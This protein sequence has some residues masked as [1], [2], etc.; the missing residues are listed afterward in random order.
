MNVQ[1]VM[2]GVT[3]AQSILSLFST[4]KDLVS[5]AKQFVAP[6]ADSDRRVS[7]I[8]FSRFM[9][10]YLETEGSTDPLMMNDVQ[11]DDTVVRVAQTVAQMPSTPIQSYRFRQWVMTLAQDLIHSKDKNTLLSFA[12]SIHADYLIA[13]DKILEMTRHLKYDLAHLFVATAENYQLYLDGLDE[14]ERKNAL[15]FIDWTDS[16]KALVHK[17]TE[18]TSQPLLDAMRSLH[19]LG[20][21]SQG[22]I[23]DFLCEIII[24]YFESQV[25]DV[26]LT[27]SASNKMKP[28][29][30]CP[31]HSLSFDSGDYIT[32][33]INAP[34]LITAIPLTRLSR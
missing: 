18:G 3:T 21:V 32:L 8:V 33:D 23:T 28:G 7:D 29:T 11:I 15:S 31:E 10:L 30:L 17:V 22:S 2:A 16:K 9:R 26:Q 24:L 20:Q 12:R 1:A 6:G 27:H 14:K 13:S 19:T 25:H 34:R 4:S 5:D